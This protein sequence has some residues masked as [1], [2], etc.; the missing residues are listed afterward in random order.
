MISTILYAHPLHPGNLNIPYGTTQHDAMRLT[1][2]NMESIRIFR[3]TVELEK[4]LTNQVCT[5]INE[6]FYE[7]VINPRTNIVTDPL[8]GFLT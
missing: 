2:E 3:E 1:M 6:T 4:N 7:E 5:T 8:S